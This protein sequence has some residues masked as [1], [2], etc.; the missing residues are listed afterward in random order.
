MREKGFKSTNLGK[1]LID[2]LNGS[3]KE[4]DEIY[5]IISDLMLH[6]H[7]NIFIVFHII[8]SNLSRYKRENESTIVELTSL[9]SS[10]ES[11]NKIKTT[12]VFFPE[13]YPSSMLEG[14][15]MNKK[16]NIFEY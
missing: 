16:V 2:A 12:I 14:L 1:D 13:S 5:K 3:K 9:M 7:F 15:I 6:S 4:M 8:N 10:N 11:S